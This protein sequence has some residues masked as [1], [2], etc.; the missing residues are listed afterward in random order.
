M[1]STSSTR[2]GVVTRSRR[3]SSAAWAWD[4]TWPP[5]PGWVV[6]QQLWW[7][8]VSAAIDGDFDLAAA[9]AFAENTPT[10]R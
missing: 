1:L 8:K 5:R 2:R 6:R 3:D 10:L 7:R 9:D 4:A